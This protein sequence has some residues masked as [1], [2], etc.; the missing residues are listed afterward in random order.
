MSRAIWAIVPLL[1]VN[2]ASPSPRQPRVAP[3]PASGTPSATAEIPWSA[4]R[5]L[6]WADF[7][8]PAPG[9][10]VE[11]ARTVYIL[12][13]ESRCRG[14]EFQFKVVALFLP[15]HSWVR[16]HVLVDPDARARVLA[17]EQTHFDLTE[18]YARRMRRHFAELYNP[19]GLVEEGVRTFVDRFVREEA[20]A[21]GRYDKETRYG[22]DAAR[23][24]RWNRDI[25]DMLA[26]L[27][28]FAAAPGP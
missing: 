20:E 22:L 12:S 1:V 17:H 2:C 27:E 21:Q 16:P 15:M 14:Q 25:A 13:A 3:P 23:Q 26:A 5:R 7:R 18:V 11:V 8:G 24:D 19:C 10:T 4:E 6:A 9:G 28:K